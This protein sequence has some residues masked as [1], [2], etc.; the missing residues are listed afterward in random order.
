MWLITATCGLT[1]I[2][3]MYEWNRGAHPPEWAKLSFAFSERLLWAIWLSWLTLA[4]ATGRA[5][6]IT[7]FLSWGSIHSTQPAII[8]RLFNSSAIL[9]YSPLHSKRK[10]LFLTPQCGD[11]VLRRPSDLLPPEP[12]AVRR[13][14]GTNGA[15]RK[16]NNDAKQATREAE[17][18]QRRQTLR[19]RRI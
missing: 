4:C 15:P 8:R 2:L 14:R 17:W 18:E 7:H 1:A 19:G 6:F 13:L 9:P 3:S 11:P 16:T 5:S 10:T 12:R